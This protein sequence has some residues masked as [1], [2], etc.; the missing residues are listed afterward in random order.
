MEKS[1]AK[2]ER[3]IQRIENMITKQTSQEESMYVTEN[4]KEGGCIVVNSKN[5]KTLINGI[6][7]VKWKVCF[8]CQPQI[9]KDH[10]SFECSCPYLME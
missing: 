5:F 9:G 8:N 3:R 6:E 2:K 10:Y 4:R 7:T 1:V